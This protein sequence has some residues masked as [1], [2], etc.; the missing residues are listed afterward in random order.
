MPFFMCREAVRGS[1]F[2]FLRT[3]WAK[4]Y[5]FMHNYPF[6]S[7]FSNG[8]FHADFRKQHLHEE[9]LS[10]RAVRVS[11]GQWN[12]MQIE[13]CRENVEPVL[14]FWGPKVCF[15]VICPVHRVSNQYA[16]APVAVSQEV[17]CFYSSRCVRISVI[18]ASSACSSISSEMSSRQVGLPMP[19]TQPLMQ[20]IPSMKLFG[21]TPLLALRSAAL[22]LSIPSQ[23]IALSSKSSTF[24]SFK[25]SATAA[26]TPPE[27][28]EHS[29]VV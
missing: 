25:I 8:K 21:R 15:N 23:E 9:C 27:V 24:I 4:R 26:A 22:H 1:R 6:S 12:K 16:E 20:T 19:P 28:A 13:S 29:S 17:H 14:H 10:E 3:V 7:N 2:L 5:D 11:C 18:S